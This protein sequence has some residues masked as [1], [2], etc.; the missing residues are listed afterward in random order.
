MSLSAPAQYVS[1]IC[2]DPCLDASALQ[3]GVRIYCE[4]RL[5]LNDYQ[6]KDGTQ[7]QGLSVLASYVRI[8]AIGK[9][10]PKQTKPATARDIAA[11]SP[12]APIGNGAAPFDDDVPF[13]AEMR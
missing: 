9:N 3:Q 13:A 4:G 12:Q 6:A 8:S 7:R 11:K 10:R 1:V 5:Q 2:F